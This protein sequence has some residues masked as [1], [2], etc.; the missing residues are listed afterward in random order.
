MKLTKI[1]IFGLATL[2]GT[3]VPIAAQ[4]NDKAGDHEAMFKQMDTNGD[5]KISA[6]EY[7]T[8]AKKTFEKMDANHDGKVTAD[9]MTAAHQ[10]VAGHKAEKGEMTAAEKIKMFDTNNDGV[11]SE[12]EYIA[13]AK[14]SFDQL[15][16]N[17]DGY[18]SK[19]EIE[20]GHK[21]MMKDKDKDK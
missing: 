13:G 21:L 19:E 9:E 11:L 3:A 15:D 16:T 10:A 14:R 7:A 18:L 8:A 12:D 5:G 17:H 20:A 4:A 6:D 1:T 2:F